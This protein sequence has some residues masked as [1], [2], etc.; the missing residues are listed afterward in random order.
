M[1][2][3]EKRYDRGLL[4]HVIPWQWT[5]AHLLLQPYTQV[6]SYATVSDHGRRT[7]GESRL[8]V[9]CLADV[10]LDDGLACSDRLAAVMW[11]DG[12]FTVRVYSLPPDR[13]TADGMRPQR[14]A[15][16]ALPSRSRP[17]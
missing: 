6:S 16:A 12:H 5:W 2:V 7:F 10:L 4:A 15:S 17:D 13:R 9:D 14:A 11:G 3:V 8:G 1:L